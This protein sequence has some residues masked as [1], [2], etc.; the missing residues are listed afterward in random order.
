[1]ITTFGGL[2]NYTMKGQN[3]KCL[4]GILNHC[5]QRTRNGFLIFYNLYDYLLFYT[6]FSVVAPRFDVIVLKLS[7]MP[8]HYHM[9]AI[10]PSRVTLFRFI[11]ELVSLF[12]RENNQQRGK[13]GPFFES[14]FGSVP[15]RGEKK[16]RSTFIYLDNNPVERHLCRMAEEY[17]WNFLAYSDS[18]HPYSTPI[19]LKK[20]SA[21]LRR[22]LKRVKEYH[23]NGWYLRYDILRQLFTPLRFEEK[24]QLTDFIISTYSIL[25]H[26]TVIQYFGS[27][28]NMLTAVHSTTG[29]EYDLKE[30]FV[31]RSDAVYEEMTRILMDTGHFGDIHEILSL[32]DEE[33]WTLFKFLS[34]KTNAMPDQ[35]AKYLQIVLRW[36]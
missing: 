7:L 14:P 26:K 22:A 5:Y 27:Y 10:A 12:S 16:V 19:N 31:G 4:H 30:R 34:E 33:K 20:A 29:S 32:P 36:K 9:G 15:K 13:K 17:R 24:E 6:L 25:D 2:N 11:Q 21:P 23:K 28:E 18:D 3:R 1:M 8:D 35:I